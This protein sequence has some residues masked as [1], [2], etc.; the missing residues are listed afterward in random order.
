MKN[1]KNVGEFEFLLS[2]NQI[3]NTV[4]ILE[5]FLPLKF[6]LVKAWGPLSP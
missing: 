1:L 2:E 6:S 4:L 5:A 3:T